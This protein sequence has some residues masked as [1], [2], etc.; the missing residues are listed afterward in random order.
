[1]GADFRERSLVLGPFAGQTPRG[2]EPACQGGQRPSPSTADP[3]PRNA[4]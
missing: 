2:G 4:Q 1:M 3:Q